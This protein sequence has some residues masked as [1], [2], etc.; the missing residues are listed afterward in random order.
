MTHTGKHA[1]FLDR[2]RLG[3]CLLA[4]AALMAAASPGAAQ[5]QTD[6]EATQ[7]LRSLAPEGRMPA[8]GSPAVAAPV[9]SPVIIDVTIV[10]N[11]LPQAVRLDLARRVDLMVFF[12]HGSTALLP[13]S[14]RALF[15]LAN[16]L[17]SEILLDQAFLIA[18]HTDASG[19][20]AYNVKLSAGRAVAVREW[21]V[22]VGGVDPRRLAVHGFGP[23]LPRDRSNPRAR[24]NRRVEIIGYA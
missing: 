5:G 15:Q 11:G 17:K 22:S 21:L 4:S 10:N 9:S 7:L 23:D 8:N 24:V 12:D 16:A 20:R 1:L 14:Q 13:S 19:P 3:R 18:G 2:R 6:A